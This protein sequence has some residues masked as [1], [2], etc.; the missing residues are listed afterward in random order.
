IRDLDG[1]MECGACA[2]NCPT[3]AIRVTPGVGCA[4]YIIQTWIKCKEAASCKGTQC[5]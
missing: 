2:Q 1:C 3:N 5:C 4:S